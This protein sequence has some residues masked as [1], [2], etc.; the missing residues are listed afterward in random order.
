M[1]DKV[2][3]IM[4]NNATGKIITKNGLGSSNSSEIS[5]PY[6][7]PGGL[8][9]DHNT[10]QLISA[11]TPSGM[12]IG[13]IIIHVGVTAAISSEFVI[14]S[15][16]GDPEKVTKPYGLAF[17]GENIIAVVYDEEP[18]PYQ[19]GHIVIFSGKTGVVAS[20]FDVP[21]GTPKGLTWDGENLVYI[22]SSGEEIYILVGKTGVVSSH[23]DS[24]SWGVNE[25]PWGV[26]WDGITLAVID[27]GQ[28]VWVRCTYP[29]GAYINLYSSSTYVFGCTVDGRIIV[30]T[31][32]TNV[33][34][35]VTLSRAR[36][37]AEVT[38]AGGESVN[39]LRQ[40]EYKKGLEGAIS[41]VSGIAGLE[42]NYS[43][44]ITG[45][46][47][48]SLYYFR[49][50]SGK[51]TDPAYGEWLTF[52]TGPEVLNIKAELNSVFARVLLYGEIVTL[53]GTTMVERG[54]EYKIQDAEP[55][56]EDT[57]TEV[58][59]FSA[60]F[61]AE[62]YSLRN[63][64]LYDQ[65]YIADNIIW[66][67]RAYCKDDGANK[68]V[69]GTWMK[70]MPTVITEAVSAI[71]YNQA[72]GN[73]IVVKEG[74]SGLT[75]RGFEVKHKFSGR[76]SDSW[77][78]EIAGFEG[79][80]EAK[81]T[82]NDIGVI[83]DFY[84]AGDL[85]KTVLEIDDL[86]LGVFVITIGEMIGSWP[87]ADDC[88]IE[89]KVYKCRAFA[90][91]EFGTVYGE[92]VDFPTPPRSYLT[93][94]PNGNG[95]GGAEPT[96]GETTVVKHEG[97]INL[98]EEI[99]ATRRGF[100][101]GTTEAADEFDVHEDGSFTNGS[102]DMMLPD[103]LP[104]TTYYI[105]AYIVVNGITY[106]GEM[107]IVPTDSEGTKDED[108]YPTP[109]FSPHGQDYREMSTKV[110]AESL[111]SQGVIDFSGGKKTLSITN[112]LIQANPN[113]KVIA[114]NYLDRFK[115]AKTRMTVTF[116]TPLPFEREDTVD[117]SYGALLFKEDDEGVVLFKEDGEG[118][119]VLL[120]K[121]TM[122]IKKINSVGLVKTE[123]SIEYVAELDLEHE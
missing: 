33:A 21:H 58:K 122:I 101:Y 12:N 114:N 27:K 50:K 30:P 86:E 117:F 23:F 88:L 78:F 2:N 102:F 99:Y 53:L 66:W 96:V 14:P 71:N 73:G 39:L 121:V 34:D 69:A 40:F 63:K 90:S 5:A 111:A 1:T 80:L 46:D 62:E 105:Y 95:G 75:E 35:D 64:T 83:T 104:A 59:E 41:T 97:I 82:V 116:P 79:E 113:A 85:I 36:M 54:F 70:N 13:K 93:N 84:W 32:I 123:E 29:A 19:S 47:A 31:V 76:L 43:K 52:Y 28:D 115:L 61:A 107:E 20:R 7:S 48:D 42:G 44:L 108:E 103:L 17:D 91:N 72:D 109:H 9:F 15:V 67:F 57:G 4:A 120:D 3:L 77:K 65:Q 100:R 118:L 106:E 74:A 94:E 98:P 45:L 25:D 11:Y 81:T 55:G 26:A 22:D 37:H 92:E 18:A 6:G 51:Y 38:D 49:A 10:G 68:Y 60:G 87:V 112:H 119:S 56:I 24:P 8:T 110:F 16:N 89:G